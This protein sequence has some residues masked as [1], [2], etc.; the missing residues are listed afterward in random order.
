MSVSAPPLTPP[1][2][3][4]LRRPAVVRVIWLV[5]ALS[6]LTAICVASLAI[7]T[8]T[9]SIDEVLAALTGDTSSIGV[10]P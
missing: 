1:D 5:V 4:I 9:V 10:S 2:A 8:R 7:G 6:A 3:A